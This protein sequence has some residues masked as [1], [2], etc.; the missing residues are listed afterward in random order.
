MGKIRNLI[1]FVLIVVLFSSCNDKNCN[2]LPNSFNNYRQAL[3]EVKSAKFEINDKINTSKSSWIRGASFYSCDLQTGYLIIKTDK[4]EYIHQDI[5]IEVWNNFK[6]A[7]S[8]G[9]YYSRN[10]RGKYKIK[11]ENY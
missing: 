11:I 4:K 1:A 8:F 7:D 3:K 2:Q 6:K 9:R 10:I 5:P